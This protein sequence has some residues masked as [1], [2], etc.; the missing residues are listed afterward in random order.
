MAT[1]FIGAARVNQL[2][3]LHV[4][5]S[6]DAGVVT[7]AAQNMTLPIGDAAAAGWTFA[8]V[9][10]AGPARIRFPFTTGGTQARCAV[11]A[12]CEWVEVF[13]T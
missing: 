13:L 9:A 10:A 11:A 6:Q 5:A 3:L 2:F 7:I 4:V 12:R 8:A 1:G